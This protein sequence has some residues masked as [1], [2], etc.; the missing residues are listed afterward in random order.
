MTLSLGLLNNQL[1]VAECPFTSGELC[2]QS[3][4]MQGQAGEEQ[5]IGATKNCSASQW[6]FGPLLSCVFVKETDC[7]TRTAASNSS[8]QRTPNKSMWN[9]SRANLKIYFK[10]F[11]VAV[12]SAL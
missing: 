4:V 5:Q 2:Q 12:S 7:L 11:I 8:D 3:G 1:R 9:N 10:E 6:I